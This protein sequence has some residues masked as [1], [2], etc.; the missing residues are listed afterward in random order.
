MFFNDLIYM[1]VNGLKNF[2][3]REMG[4]L[5]HQ[6]ILG[7]GKYVRLPAVKSSKIFLTSMRD[8]GIIVMIF[9]FTD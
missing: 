7:E 2:L 1:S 8:M 5:R 3:C 9:A 6:S 4:F